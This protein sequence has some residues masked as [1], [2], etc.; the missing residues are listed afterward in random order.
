MTGVT[1]ATGKVRTC[2]WFDGTGLEAARY[3]TSLLPDSWIENDPGEADTPPLV[4]NF[5]LAGTPYQAL[6]GGPRYPHTPAASISVQ[7]ADQAETDRLWDALVA[8]GQANRCGWLTDRFGLSWQIVPQQLSETVGGPDTD[9]AARATQAMLTM[10]KI[11][12]AA[13]EAAYR[14]D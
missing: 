7:T 5:C 4:V 14:G 9:G 2:L 11:D 10:A 13:L 12:I 6:N 3:Y 1:G 8:G